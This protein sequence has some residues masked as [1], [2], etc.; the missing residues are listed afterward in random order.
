ML[1]LVISIKCTEQMSHMLFALQ[2]FFHTVPG[3]LNL[4]SCVTMAVCSSPINHKPQIQKL[5]D[6]R[7]FWL[8]SHIRNDEEE[9]VSESTG[10]KWLLYDEKFGPEKRQKTDIQAGW[11]I[12][13]ET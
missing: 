8:S 10:R 7:S 4:I 2:I 12:L 3:N 9:T 1:T 5:R 13:W 11:N 6:K